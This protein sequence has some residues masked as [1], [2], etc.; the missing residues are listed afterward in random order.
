[1]YLSATQIKPFL[2]AFV[3]LQIN[4]TTISVVVS[5]RPSVFS[6]CNNSAPTERIF[7]KLDM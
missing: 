2:C 7:T 1:M 3:K 4:K 6:A 5:V